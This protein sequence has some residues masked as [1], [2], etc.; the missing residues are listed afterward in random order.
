MISPTLRYIVRLSR[1][2]DSISIPFLFLYVYILPVVLQ[3]VHVYLSSRL[4]L[5]DLYVL[6]LC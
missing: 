2:V 4:L 3:H 1:L 6:S 5:H